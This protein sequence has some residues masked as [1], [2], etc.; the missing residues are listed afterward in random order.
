[1]AGLGLASFLAPP[2]I[3]AIV[4]VAKPSGAIADPAPATSAPST[5]PPAPP[6]RVSL[7]QAART[8]REE[9]EK[10]SGWY[11]ATVAGSAVICIGEFPPAAPL[12]GELRARFA[13]NPRIMLICIDNTRG[14][15]AIV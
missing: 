5:L 2:P 9:I 11:G 7:A 12:S 3:T 15:K 6:A 10:L 13:I 1:A 14:S 4:Q 8:A